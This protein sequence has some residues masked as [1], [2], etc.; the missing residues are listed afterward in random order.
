[1]DDYLTFSNITVQDIAD[2]I[3][4]QTRDDEI[5]L[6]YDDRIS[7]VFAP[8]PSLATLPQLLEAQGEYLRDTT[9]VTILD[10][11]SKRQ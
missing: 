1:M 11:D 4:L 5:T 2:N 6:E 7:L 3:I 9:T 8:A 10:D